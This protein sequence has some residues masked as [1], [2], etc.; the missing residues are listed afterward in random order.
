[1]EATV[2]RV[3]LFLLFGVLGG[4]GLA[5]LGGLCVAAPGDGA[6]RRADGDRARDRR[7]RATPTAASRRPTPTTRSPSWPARSTT[8]SRRSRVRAAETRPR[9]SASGE[10]VADASHELR[11]PLTSVLANLELLAE[12][13]RRRARRGRALGAALL[14]ADAPPR[15][16]PPAARP[17]RRRA[18]RRRASPLD[19]GARAGRGRRGARRRSPTDA[20][21]SVD[22]PSRRLRRRRARR[23]APPRA[24]PDRERAPATRRRAR[25]IRAV[26]RPRRRRGRARRRGRRPRHPARAARPALRALRP[27]RGRRGGSFGLGLSIVRAV[28]E[29]HGGTV[30]VETPPGG[31]RAPASWSASRRTRSPHARRRTPRRAR[32]RCASR[33]EAPD[34]AQPG[35]TAW[36]SAS[37]SE[38]VPPPLQSQYVPAG[39]ALRQPEELSIAVPSPHS[40]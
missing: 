4:A 21:L 18:R 5:L 33:P 15:R 31:R 7:A 27:R 8:C 12:V 39:A 24:Q 17:R 36:R 16:R 23:A 13:A 6:D 11:T 20:P 14:A 32:R 9:W 3:R 30:S 25:A 28:A 19:L 37:G 35:G 2:N 22:A 26:G 38:T 34:G 40:L 29:A 1:M 10:F